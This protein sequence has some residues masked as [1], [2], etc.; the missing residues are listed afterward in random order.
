MQCLFC[1]PTTGLVVSTENCIVI[2]LFPVLFINLH[3]MIHV[4]S[5]YTCLQMITWALPKYRETF[6]AISFNF[7][8]F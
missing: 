3:F 5:V 2:A 1:S 8:Y 6:N 4:L 7:L